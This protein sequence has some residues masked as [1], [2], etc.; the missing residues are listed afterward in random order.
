M[1]DQRVFK[2]VSIDDPASV[3][4]KLVGEVCN[5]DCGYCY[6]KRKPYAG[7]RILQPERIAEFLR[8]M[9]QQQLAVELHGGE[10]LLY[11][12]E[13][14]IRLSAVMRGLGSRLSRITLQTNGTLLVPEMLHMLRELFPTLQIGISI[15][16]PELLNDQRVDLRGRPS[17]AGAL[18]ALDVCA[19]EGV[20]V[21]AISVVTK[22]SL[23]H[24]QTLMRFFADQPAVKVVKLVPC[25]DAN[26]RQGEGPSRRGQIRLLI[27]SSA[28]RSLPWAIT[29]SEYASFVGEAAT[30]WADEVGPE[31]FLL[32]P[33]ASA[34]RK[35]A[36]VSTSNCHFG[37]LKCSHVYTLY[38]D[39]SVG[40]CDELERRSSD[41]G[42]VNGAEAFAQSTV[43]WQQNLDSETRALLAMCA[44]C[45][46]A[47]KCGGGCIAS[48]RRMH[49]AGQSEAYCAHRR[50]IVAS[51]V[52]TARTAAG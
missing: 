37:S 49:Q 28:G 1:S 6:E 45:D 10:P 36:N 15:D 2:L 40:S 32:E 33:S 22:Q 44:A 52:E 25:F 9:P 47:T 39:G 30:Y 18:A 21:G 29:P 26:V 31:R 27:E 35:V 11:P 7:S 51:A 23:P 17:F 19:R 38:P 20:Y 46:I 12:R 43:A 34:L 50:T 16:G 5:L 13:E 8:T 42:P 4:L 48:R 14:F 3:I 24:A 41:Y